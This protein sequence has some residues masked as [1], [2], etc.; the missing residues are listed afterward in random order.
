V[1]GASGD[2]V[3]TIK[4]PQAFCIGSWPCLDYP[5]NVVTVGDTEETVGSIIKQRSRVVRELCRDFTVKCKLICVEV[6]RSKLLK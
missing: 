6:G 3:F 5:F 4:G 1:D 2:Q